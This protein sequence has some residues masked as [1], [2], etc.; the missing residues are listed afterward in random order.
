MATPISAE[1]VAVDVVNRFLVRPELYT[2]QEGVRFDAGFSVV[3][4]F[5]LSSL[6]P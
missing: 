2:G 1:N 6:G 5:L 3:H 4:L